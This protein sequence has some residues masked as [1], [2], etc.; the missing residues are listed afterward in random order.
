MGLAERRAALAFSTEE[1]P[2]WRSKFDQAA[3]FEVPVEVAWDELAVD[4]YAD[5]YSAFFTKVYFRPLAEAL[6]AITIDDLG[7]DALKAG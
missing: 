7:K 2:G 5:D 4:G 1:Y 3:C 6:A